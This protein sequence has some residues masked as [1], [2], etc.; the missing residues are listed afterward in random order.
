MPGLDFS[1]L[2]APHAPA[3]FL[4]RHWEKCALLIKRNE[5]E[6]FQALLCAANIQAFLSLADQLPADA[7]ELIGQAIGAAQGPE[8]SRGPAE[9]FRN[10]STIRVRGIQRYCDPLKDLCRDVEAQLSFPTRA[11]LY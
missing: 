8:S 5:P 7:F 9:F 1:Y 11:N 6:R 2:I 10:G 3:D 4:A